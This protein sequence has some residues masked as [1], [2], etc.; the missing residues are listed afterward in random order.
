MWR[1]WITSNRVFGIV[2]FAGLVQVSPE[3]FVGHAGDF[4]G[5][6]GFDFTK[7]FHGVKAFDWLWILV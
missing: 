5:N 6:S 2:F 3:F 7:E 4:P 1:G